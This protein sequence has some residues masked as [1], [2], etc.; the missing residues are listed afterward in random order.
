MKEAIREH[1]ISLGAD[2]CGFA[3]IDSF[4]DA[5]KGF[6]PADIWQECKS[7][8]S[9]AV[10]LPKGLLTIN[11]RLIYAHYNYLTCPQADAIAFNAAKYI[12]AEYKCRAVPL[13]CDSPYEYW[14]EEI[15]EGRGLLSMKHAAVKAGLGSIGKN[16][17]FACKQFGNMVTLGCVLTDL[18]LASDAPAES[19]CIQNCRKCVDACP[20]N[21][22]ESNS[23]NQRRCRT[24]T[25]GKTDRGYDTVDC[26]ACRTVCPLNNL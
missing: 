5:P 9:F 26:N 16:T 18:D 13:P 15:L 1:F 24:N 14:D 8:V 6:S 23:V 21:A 17:L 20:V 25:Y 7:I 12:E 4:S 10:A 3:N 22:I 19:L 11:P 2:L